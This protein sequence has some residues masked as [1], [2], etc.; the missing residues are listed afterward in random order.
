MKLILCDK[1]KKLVKEFKKL[2]S[3]YFELVVD[4]TG[5]VFK[6]KKKYPNAK[7]VTASNKD[8]TFGGGLDAALKSKYP[9][10]CMKCKEFGSSDNLFFTITVDENYR[11]DKD[12]L[13]R[14][15][16]GMFANI[17]KHSF[18]LTGLG[19]GIGGL[20]II[21]FITVLTKVLNADLRN[22]DLS[23]ANLRTANLS[24]ANLS[25]VKNLTN[26]SVD[27]FKDFEK[28]AKGYIVYKAIGN[29][30]YT[31]CD[32]W[33][34]KKNSIITE[35]VNPCKTNSC[36]CGVNFGTKKWIRDNL[37]TPDSIWE[38]LLAFEDM[39]DLVI[40]YD[41]NGKARC[42]KLKLL[43]QGE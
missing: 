34:I 17:T 35:V 37:S 3:E 23:S 39:C 24:C 42:G 4:T 29:T 33:V 31:K 10:E 5:D 18:I 6:A 20:S 40:P 8:F 9:D 7:I 26:N 27:F 41:Y 16:V 13:L 2:K 11:C 14:A 25:G 38:C 21:E 32:D 30:V 28:T 36:G 12:I 19:T 22:A 15:L 43:K 1:N